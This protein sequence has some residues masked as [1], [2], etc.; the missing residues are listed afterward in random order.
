MKTTNKLIIFVLTLLSLAANAFALSPREEL[1]QMVE[2]LQKAP[3][4]TA[5]REKIIKLATSITPA[6]AVPLEAEKF[7]GRAL[8]AFKNA[9]SESEMLNSAREYMKAADAAPWVADYYFNLCAILEKANRPTEAIRACKF[10]L[11]AA[12]A[13]PDA[14]DVR[15]RIAGLEYAVERLQGNVTRRR[16][17]L[18]MSDMYGDAAKVAQIG[19]SRI[20][21]KLVSSLYRGVWRNQLMLTDMTTFATQRYELTPVDTTFQHEDRVQ[22]S[23][24]YRLTIT[25]DGRITFGGVGSTQAEIVTSIPELHQLR[26]TQMNNCQIVTKNGEFFVMLAQGGAFSDDGVLVAGSLFFESD[27]AG[28]LRGEKPGWFPAVF[29][30]HQQTPGV[31]SQQSSPDAQGFSLASFDACRQASNDSLGWLTP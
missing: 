6:L 27:C 15:K 8:Y 7:D 9:K 22:S 2:Q 25:S 31:T 19:A 28:N 16:E 12:P 18:T 30:P 26:N 21:L 24:Y 14:G 4:D 20:S 1:Q 23:P 5:L 3:N 11:I 29:I 13:A 10:Y 17:C